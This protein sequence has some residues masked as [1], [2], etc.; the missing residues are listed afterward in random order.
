MVRQ[1]IAFHA[2]SCTPRT[3]N[4]TRTQTSMYHAF[5]LTSQTKVYQDTRSSEN[6]AAEPASPRIMAAYGGLVPGASPTEA[7]CS[8]S[9][10]RLRMRRTTRDVGINS[11]AILTV[12]R[13]ICKRAVVD[14][15]M[16]GSPFD[17]SSFSPSQA[18]FYLLRGA[19][20]T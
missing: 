4:G 16:V 7:W 8:S 17:Y 6:R 18:D 9:P 11:D 5:D 1:G 10:P 2:C 20:D 15:Y 3:C 19:M 12:V 14:T 13:S